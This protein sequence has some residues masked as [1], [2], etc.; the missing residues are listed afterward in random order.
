MSLLLRL[1]SVIAATASVTYL[2]WFV[3]CMSDN[4]DPFDSSDS[5]RSFLIKA[6]LRFTLESNDLESNVPPATH[7]LEQL[8][9]WHIQ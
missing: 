7:E 2:L 4:K 9:S 6:E 3:F 8:E 1:A 5:C